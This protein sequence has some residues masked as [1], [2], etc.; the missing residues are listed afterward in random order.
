ML[1]LLPVSASRHAPG[2]YN[3]Q[4]GGISA[5][6]SEDAFA[7]ESAHARTALLQ[8]FPHLLLGCEQGTYLVGQGEFVSRLIRG[9]TRVTMWVIGVI[10]LLTE[11]P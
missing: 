10:N 5:S 4:K 2:I 1:L 11:S 3:A 6:L 9:I 7:A 8:R